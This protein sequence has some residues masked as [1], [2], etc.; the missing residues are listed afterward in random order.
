[1]KITYAVL[2]LLLVLAGMYCSLWVISSASLACTACNCEYSLFAPTFRC[3][4]PVIAIML[5]VVSFAGAVV[6]FVVRS[7]LSR[8]Q[9]AGSER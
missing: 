3:R 9:R 1:M 8:R 5:A 6:A 7:R 4:Q 2:G